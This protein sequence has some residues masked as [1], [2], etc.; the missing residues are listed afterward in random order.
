MAHHWQFARPAFS[1]LALVIG[2]FAAT[3]QAALNQAPPATA[4]A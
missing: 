4:A 1:S 3:A 2:L